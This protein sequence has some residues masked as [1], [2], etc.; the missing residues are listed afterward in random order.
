MNTFN[1]DSPWA[2]PGSKRPTK[3]RPRQQ[4]RARECAMTGLDM[5]L[6][7]LLACSLSSLKSSLEVGC[8]VRWSDGAWSC[9][10]NCIGWNEAFSQIIGGAI[11]D[12]HR[13]R[14]RH[15]LSLECT[16]CL[17]RPSASG[18]ALNQASFSA[19]PLCLCLLLP[20]GERGNGRGPGAAAFECPTAD[21]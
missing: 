14:S 5:L 2:V 1:D 7:F 20:V 17:V 9:V 19:S 15:R 21:L 4:R 8:L 16:S 12:Q 3:A 10:L 11:P 18:L 6:C 13:N